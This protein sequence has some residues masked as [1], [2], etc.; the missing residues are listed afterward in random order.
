VV[1]VSDYIKREDA[2]IEIERFGGYL[3]DD[4]LYRIKLALNRLNR[5]PS[6]DVVEV[7]RCKDCKWLKPYASQYGAGQFCECP[8]SFGGQGIKKPDDYCSYGERRD[9][10]EYKDSIINARKGEE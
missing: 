10:E 4:M 7:V 5:L 2:I 8:C 3:D 6:A 1:S 9:D